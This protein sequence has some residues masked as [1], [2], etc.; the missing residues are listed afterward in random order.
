MSSDEREPK[1]SIGG[2]R[3][4]WWLGG[5]ALVAIA[6]VG[7]VVAVDR[8]HGTPSRPPASAAGT[9]VECTVEPLSGLALGE[10][11]PEWVLVDPSGGYVVT[12]QPRDDGRPV[13]VLWHGGK[14]VPIPLPDGAGGPE[15]VGMAAVN[16]GGTA[17]G[18]VSHGGHRSAFV[19]RDGSTTRLPGLP[20]YGDSDAEGI[21]AAGDIVGDA[22]GAGGDVPVIW[23]AEAPGAVRRIGSAPGSAAAIGDDGTVV[24]TGGAGVPWVWNASGDGHALALP[25]DPEVKKGRA[26]AVR[27][28]WAAG[29]VGITDQLV[30]AET[31]ARWNLRTGAVKTFPGLT[32][33]GA[34]GVNARGDLV[35]AHGLGGDTAIRDGRALNLSV[36]RYQGPTAWATW[37]SD[38][39]RTLIGA[40]L[41]PTGTDVVRWHC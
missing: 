2:R 13:P 27:G 12:E 29:W 23:P 36:G 21:D 32:R 40:A 1:G 9:A 6:A 4:V 38:D 39:G 28:D 20:G 26:L 16:A 5:V 11:S 15:D 18:T 14:A 7:T 34:R 25:P 24:G 8:T 22:S 10:R 17:V 31:P 3:T 19:Y 33:A 30:D 35:T 41:G 37:I